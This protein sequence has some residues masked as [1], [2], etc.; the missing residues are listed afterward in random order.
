MNQTSVTQDQKDD[1]DRLV[2]IYLNG[3]T[4]P[5][6]D[7]GWAGESILSRLIQ[8]HGQLPGQSGND[9]SNMSMIIAIE[10]LRGTHYDFPKIKTA[11]DWTLKFRPEEAYALCAK[12]AYNGSIQ[13]VVDGRERSYRDEDRGRLTGLGLHGY[14]YH[15]KKAYC[16]VRDE[17]ERL[18]QFVCELNSAA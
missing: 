17:L 12:I 8:F 2:N 4:S 13:P 3:I 11:M 16:T 18:D 5:D 1:I 7:A 14:R 6:S 9:Q 10:S 15:L